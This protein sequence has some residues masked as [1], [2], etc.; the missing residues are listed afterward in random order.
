[1]FILL[2]NENEFFP[3]ICHLPLVTSHNR[4]VNNKSN[5]GN[6]HSWTLMQVFT[7][8][9][10]ILFLEEDDNTFPPPHALLEVHQN[11]TKI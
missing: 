9:G 7:S 5:T 6:S 10:I 1:M 8:I 11:L 3:P 4:S 2:N